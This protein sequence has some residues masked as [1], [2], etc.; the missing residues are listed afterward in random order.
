MYKVCFCFCW[1]CFVVLT[2]F[3]QCFGGTCCLHLQG[4]QLVVEGRFLSC[5]SGRII[6][7]NTSYLVCYAVPLDEVFPLYWWITGASSSGL[8]S[9]RRMI[10]LCLPYPED[11]VTKVL[12]NVRN[13]CLNNTVSH[14]KILETSAILLWQSGMTQ[15]ICLCIT[16]L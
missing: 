2:P 3:F 14:S 5:E 15:N 10:L 1:L 12:W 4:W 8:S 13:H 6:A 11:A 7:E 16:Q 9:A